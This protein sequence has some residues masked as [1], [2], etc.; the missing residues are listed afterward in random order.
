MTKSQQEAR[1]GF[2]DNWTIKLPKY[3]KLLEGLAD[4][5]RFRDMILV[6]TFGS[7]TTQI[8]EDMEDGDVVME[9]EQK[10]KTKKE[11][12]SIPK[13]ADEDRPELLPLIVKL[14][15][16]KLANRKL[17]QT[18]DRRTLIYQFLASLNPASEY[19]IFFA[20]VLAP[21]NLPQQTP[22]EE[23][24][25]KCLQKVSFGT[26][27]TFVGTL[28]VIFTQLGTLLIKAG[29]GYLKLFTQIL[30]LMLAQAK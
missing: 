21:L 6:I 2:A 24:V 13:L 27:V 10:K 16:S 19:P 11:V 29:Q 18:Q 8:Q 14:L 30:V 3:Q 17:K 26:F 12:G 1:G 25:R 9:E 7:Q 4:D 5:T 28:E 23:Q 22:T 15:L 20:E